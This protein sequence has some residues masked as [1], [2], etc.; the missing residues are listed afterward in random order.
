MVHNTSDGCNNNY[1]S[2][3]N[4]GKDHGLRQEN[5]S[6]CDSYVISAI[7]FRDG[8]TQLTL[9]SAYTVFG[10][11]KWW[12]SPWDTFPDCLNCATSFS[13]NLGTL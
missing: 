4:M 1:K 13:L 12:L 5:L 2:I 11:S 6:F 10:I 9:W 3:R 8:L 7:K